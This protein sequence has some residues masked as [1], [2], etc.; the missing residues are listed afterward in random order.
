MRR[1]LAKALRARVWRADRNFNSAVILALQQRPAVEKRSC[2]GVAPTT[3]ARQLAQECE[4]DREPEYDE[5]AEE[6]EGQ[7]RE[8]IRIMRHGLR[9]DHGCTSGGLTCYVREVSVRKTGAD[10]RR[11][12]DDPDGGT[13]PCVVL[14]IQ[15]RQQGCSSNLA[16]VRLG[17]RGLGSIAI[18]PATHL[19]SPRCPPH[20]SELL[21]WGIHCRHSTGRK[22]W[23]DIAYK[24]EPDAAPIA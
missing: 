22:A 7:P 2:H 17:I 14:N 19:V 20:A 4:R 3:S 11:H 5:S 21:M 16:F 18:A 6:N 24:F 9:R 10:H 15:P 1:H 8:L 12:G 13:W 23:N